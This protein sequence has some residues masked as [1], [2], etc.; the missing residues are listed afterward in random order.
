MAGILGR[1]SLWGATRCVEGLDDGAGGDFVGDLSEELLQQLFGGGRRTEVREMVPGAIIVMEHLESGK[2][3]GGFDGGEVGAIFEDEFAD[4]RNGRHPEIV[5]ED[6][7][8]DFGEES[9]ESE[10]NEDVVEAMVAV[11]EDDVKLTLGGSESGKSGEGI[12]LNELDGLAKLL[13]GGEGDAVPAA[14]LER[15]NGG[16]GAAGGEKI[17]SAEAVGHADFE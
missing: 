9:G 7:G 6:D 12:V 5:E 8:A 2:S 11:N 16:V 3:R 15:I 1:M 13:Y 17:E 10:I 4:E 14:A